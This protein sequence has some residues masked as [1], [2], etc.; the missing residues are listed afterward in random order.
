VAHFLK[1]RALELSH[2]KTSIRHVDDG[3]DFLGQN[4]RRYGAKILLK[5]SR[6]NVRTFLGKIDEEIQA[7]RWLPQC[8]QPDRA[9]QPEDS[10][11]G[12]V[13]PTRVER[14]DLCALDDL[15]FKKLWRWARRRHRG[16]S[17][18]W[19]RAKYFT[20]PGDPRWRFRGIVPAGD[21][22]MRAVYLCWARST[23]IRRHVKIQGAANP[24]DPSWELYFEERLAAQMASTLTGRGTARYLWLEQ[25]R[26]CLVCSQ[27]LTLEER[28]PPS[29]AKSRRHRR[30]RQPGLAA[31]Q[32]SSAS[33]Q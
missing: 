15:T 3:F 6:K 31:S 10:R 20:Q 11:L 9:A 26:K 29:L 17:A 23:T 24:Y 18:R 16:K 2:E 25:D 21:D 5:P 28:P 7:N 22:G 33:S 14:A 1:E 19:V 30:V 4:V 8:R 13:S 32:L 12:D 27:P